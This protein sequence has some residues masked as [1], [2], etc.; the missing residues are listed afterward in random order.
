MRKPD[1][2][3]RSLII[4]L[5]VLAPLLVLALLGRDFILNG[6]IIP[7]EY[8]FWLANLAVR[9]VPQYVFWAALCVLA[10]FLVVFSLLT[11]GKEP[12]S[13]EWRP[14]ART[15]RERVAF[16]TLQL[17]LAKG[18]DY[19]RLRFANYFSKLIL[20]I[21]SYSGRINPEEYDLGMQ[22]G[23]LDLPQPVLVFLKTRL[24]PLYALGP[25]SLK[26]RL[27]LRHFGEGLALRWL[28]LKEVFQ[29]KPKAASGDSFDEDVR[30]VVQ[31][32]EN[33]LEVD[34]QHDG[35]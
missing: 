28:R 23:N 20:D 2:L 1:Q 10:I 27:A 18:G 21:L 33:E 22:T 34:R 30:H 6:V 7:V 19:F 13:A 5:A 25:V 12:L 8:F 15:A 16:W 3:T 11:G 24:T 35:H 9:A 26:E 14:P 17:R 29:H 4:L 32:L 31:Y